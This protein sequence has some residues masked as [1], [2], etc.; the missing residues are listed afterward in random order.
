M[1]RN[2]S[3]KKSFQSRFLRIEPLE[4]RDLLSASFPTQSFSL[5]TSQVVESTE[6]EVAEFSDN[7]SLLN[8]DGSEWYV[9]PS[10]GLN[11]SAVEQELLERINLFRTDPSG[12]L[13]RIFSTATSDSLVARN[14]L[15]NAAISLTSYPVNSLDVF[16][17][18]MSSIEPA[19]PLA[20]NY[21][22]S[23]AASSHTSYMKARNDI[24]HQ[25]AGEDSL[26]K[27]VSKTG[28]EPGSD[29]EGEISVSENIGGGFM[30]RDGWSVASY[31]EAAFSV[32][33]GVPEHT[34]RDSMVNAAYSEIGI[35]VQQTNKS[36]GPYLVTCDFGT[37]VDGVRTDG[38]FLLGV[39]Y[40]DAD[41]D[42]F[43]D[44]GE[45]LGQAFLCIE[46]IDGAQTESVTI[47]SWDSGG[48]QIFLLNGS[49][50]VSVSGEGFSNTITKNIT[51]SDGT[52]V[53][54]DFTTG[55]VG[56]FAPVIDLNGDED[57]YNWSV[58]YEEGREEPL[59]IFTTGK[60]TITDDDSAYLYGAKV[61]F[62][63]LPDSSKETLDF[64]TTD[65][66]FDILFDYNA[67]TIS[68]SGTGTLE[69]YENIIASLTY[70]NTSEICDLSERTFH[71]S[72]FDGKNWSDEAVLTLTIHPTKLPQMTVKDLFVYEGDVG[73]KVVNFEV[74]LDSPARLDVSF[75]YNVAPGGTAVEG[76]QFVISKGDPLV[77][78]QGETRAQIECYI[79]GNYEALKSEGLLPTED[80]F[81]NPFTNFFIEIVDLEN[82]YLTNE[83]ALAKG[84]IYDDDSPIILG[85]VDRY[86]Y[87]KILTTDNSQR[88]YVFTL[89]PEDSGLFSW[90]TDTIGALESSSITIRE[91]S[92]ESDPIKVSN[93]VRNDSIVQWVADPTVEYWITV[94]SD[95]DISLI[96]AK[97]LTID[98]E[99]R[100]LVD[101]LLE[102][103]DSRL[104]ELMWDA[105][106]LQL[107]V[108]DVLWSFDGDYSRVN[109]FVTRRSDVDFSIN[110]IPF[111]S[112]AVYSGDDSVNI[113]YGE[114]RVASIIGSTV[115]NFNGSDE[116]EQIVLSGTQ[117]DDYLFYSNGT[118]YFLRSDG[119]KYLFNGV[120][121]VV[122]DGISGNN[123]AIIEDSAE[124]DRFKTINGEISLAGGGFSLVG[125]NFT[126]ID[127]RFIHGGED[128]YYAMDY[129]DD[130]TASLSRNC[131]IISGFFQTNS[132]ES[133]ITPNST[134]T[135]DTVDRVYDYVIKASGYSHFI[136]DPYETIGSVIMHGDG[137]SDSY[138]DVTVGNL[139]FYGNRSSSRASVSRVKSLTVSGI[140]PTQYDYLTVNLPDSYQAYVDGEY[141]VVVDAQT[142][143]ILNIP[144]DKVISSS[145]LG[146]SSVP[147]FTPTCDDSLSNAEVDVRQDAFVVDSL[148]VDTKAGKSVILENE[149]RD[150][151]DDV[152]TVDAI[153]STWDEG[154]ECFLET[155]FYGE[156][157]HNQNDV[158]K[159]LKSL[160]QSGKR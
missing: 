115:V 60:L 141:L 89:T 39:V 150:V 74:E 41:N 47:S 144:F 73:A 16:L 42:R 56:E 34:H 126:E 113:S 29:S 78:R 81:E 152:D 127:A 92:L 84:T 121:E 30:E 125:K 36:V 82:A 15:V 4:S 124:N 86:A 79:I 61:V 9:L 21:S 100:A 130:T 8:G 137:R 155:A 88:R 5:E 44:V 129:G 24:S 104:V 62:G 7:A 57:G 87:S 32:D 151:L 154:D 50:R 147:F 117:G 38:A 114:N 159:I 128:E 107:N 96:S 146:D 118:G 108:G 28:F 91:H 14:S 46:R 85:S 90:T 83:N 69:D 145:L 156:E 68:I 142:N 109:T 25:C 10:A 72:V 95:A 93:I 51:I 3:D 49:Y 148:Y 132:T 19:A 23:T 97:L 35:S 70:F 11:P 59:D 17:E 102:D 112:G 135:L 131:A 80:G 2:K 157:F 133:D 26:D 66:N 33:W 119:M 54:L 116:N 58:V 111:S 37:S 65:D 105:D 27:R 64:E 110:A 55:E 140:Y 63:D 67:K 76:E 12:E 13:E 139:S 31:I 123:I 101:P 45:G 158:F 149:I 136:L 122:V 103:T 160:K 138:Y 22:L 120:N 153:F 98:L 20:F 99:G 6:G 94:E 134:A 52:N 143:W 43:Y 18:E 71:F 53:K 77:I 48:Y 40:D 1:R 75:N 106:A